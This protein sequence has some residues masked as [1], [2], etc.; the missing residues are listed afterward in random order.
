MA[1]A[2]DLAHAVRRLTSPNPWVGSVVVAADGTV[3]GEGATSPPGGAHAEA[4][5][6][7]IAGPRSL[8][9]TCYTTLEPCVSYGRTPPCVGAIV[10]AGIR[11]VVV[12][13]IDPDDKVQGRGVAAL[14]DRGI[15]VVTGVLREVAEELLRPYLVQR[16]TLRPYVVLKLAATLD[17]RI[18]APDGTSK[19]ITGAGARAD[20]H[21]LRAD[22]DAVLVGAGTVR[23]DDPELKVRTYPPSR[24][25]P[26]RVVLGWARA[27]ARVQPCLEL[28]GDVRG[29]LDELGRLGVLQLLVEG[30]GGVAKQLHEL[31]V[32]DRY[33][34]YLTAGFLGGDDGIAMFAGPGARSMA[35]L[36]RGRL[37][38]LERF[39]DD[40]RLDIEPAKDR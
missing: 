29:V 38:S 3:V 39:G 1:R 28:S 17:G 26:L 9:G 21:E 15:E 19:W 33:V 4:V 22:S 8:G 40:A 37:V 6:L 14:R 25:Q 5:A 16:R 30:G 2:I 32:I 24:R 20:V 11:R 34:I 12:A 7:E 27:T 18:A 13:A 10:A 31:E 23:A 35:A 36:W